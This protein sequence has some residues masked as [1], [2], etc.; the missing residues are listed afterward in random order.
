MR[1]S[2]VSASAPHLPLMSRTWGTRPW[3]GYL[4]GFTLSLRWMTA[5]WALPDFATATGPAELMSRHAR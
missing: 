2:Q 4:R 1:L 5:S 3:N